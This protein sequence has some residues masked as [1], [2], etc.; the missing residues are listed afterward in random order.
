MDCSSLFT[1]GRGR[2]SL[3]ALA[4]LLVVCVAAFAFSFAFSGKSRAADPLPGVQAKF[5]WSPAVPAVGQTVTFEST[6][7]ATGIGNAIADYR[8]DLDGDT[9]NG[10]ETGWG[11]T[12]V[13]STTYAKP[14]SYAVRLQ[15][16]DTLD[17]RSTIKKTVTVAAKAPVASYTVAPVPPLVNQPVTFTST[18]TDADGTIAEQVWDLNGDGAY[19][20][21][22][23]PTVLRTF[24]AP[25]SYVVG[26]RVTD[27]DGAVAFHAQTI[28]VGPLPGPIGL[29]K[30]RL[31]S[32]FPVVRIAGR[33]LRGG[34]RLTRLSINA[35][36]GS[37]ITVRCKGTSCP[38]SSSVRLAK[39]V[40]FRR[41]ERRLRVG[42]VVRIYVTR[43]GAIGKYTVFKIRKGRA[44]VRKDSCLMPGS[45][46]PIACPSG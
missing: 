43:T 42:V 30:P 21:G 40:R 10:F 24:S 1:S 41:L 25:G 27:N 11:S 7:Q 5:K 22:A 35:P 14:G 17:N 28:I 32:P 29:G 8:W 38:F 18:S 2:R 3:I 33:T 37:V 19:D 9:D 31:L 16:K 39:V 4:T 26:L 36:L 34:V 15:V 46:K 6:S 44:P 20:N 13:V 45:L 12:P 23:G